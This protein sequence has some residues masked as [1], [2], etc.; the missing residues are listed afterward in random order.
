MKTMT[1]QAQ[2]TLKCLDQRLTE[3]L[4]LDKKKILIGSSESSD[5]RISDKSIS[6]YHAFLYIKGEGF[7]VKDLYSESG[8]YA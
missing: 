4:S 6:S 5:I 3:A 2:F 7:M 8:V 1:A